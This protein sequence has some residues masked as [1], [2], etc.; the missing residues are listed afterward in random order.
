MAD[1]PDFIVDN[2][3]EEARVYFESTIRKREEWSVFTQNMHTEIK[4]EFMG[5]ISREEIVKILGI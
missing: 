4:G 3:L 5:T 2:A 1:T